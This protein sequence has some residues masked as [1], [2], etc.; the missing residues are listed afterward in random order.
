[1]LSGKRLERIGDDLGGL[2][3]AVDEMG[4]RLRRLSL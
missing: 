1:M 2:H 4:L 3:R